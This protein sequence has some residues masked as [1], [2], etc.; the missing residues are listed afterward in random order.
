MRVRALGCACVC[1]I[2]SIAFATTR[3]RCVHRWHMNVDGLRFETVSCIKCMVRRCSQSH[4][5]N[6]HCKLECRLEAFMCACVRIIRETPEF[7][8]DYSWFR[9]SACQTCYTQSPAAAAVTH[10]SHYT[11]KHTAIHAHTRSHIHAIHSTHKAPHTHGCIQKATCHVVAANDGLQN[12]CTCVCA[13]VVRPPDVT[14]WRWRRWRRLDAHTT[15]QI[16]CPK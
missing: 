5:P 16:Y 1:T 9:V 15:T 14:T 4:S 12:V 3:A 13:C 8:L 10:L 6:T 2:F 7:K 11:E